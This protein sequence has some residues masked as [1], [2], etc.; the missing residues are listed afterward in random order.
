[1]KKLIFIAFLVFNLS[2]SS[3][4]VDSTVHSIAQEWLGTRYRMGGNNRNGIDCS[5][6]SRMLY[7]KVFGESLPRTAREQY[8]RTKRVPKDSLLVGDLVFFRMKTQTTWHVGVYLGD[9]MFIHAANRRT[10]VIISSLEETYYKRTFLS[11]GR[12]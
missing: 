9:G 2:A 10:G 6:F 12:L 3:Q 5:G 7:L 11:G 8:K 4:E 1:M